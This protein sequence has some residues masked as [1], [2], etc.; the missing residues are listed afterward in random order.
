MGLSLFSFFFF[1]FSFGRGVLAASEV[2]LRVDGHEARILHISPPG[3]ESGRHVPKYISTSEIVVKDGAGGL[4]SS[5]SKAICMDGDC[6]YAARK[7]GPKSTTVG[8]LLVYPLH[9]KQK[10]RITPTPTPPRME[11]QLEN[12]GRTVVPGSRPVPPQQ[13]PPG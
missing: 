13:A 10:Q 6:I 9:R 3:T 2:V 7:K 4:D 5:E 8:K 11:L 1:S 12:P